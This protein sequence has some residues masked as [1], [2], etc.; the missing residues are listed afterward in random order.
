MDLYTRIGV[1]CVQ[2]L[3]AFDLIIRLLSTSYLSSLGFVERQVCLQPPPGANGL[4]I[5]K[6]INDMLWILLTFLIVVSS[7]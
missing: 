2:T 6:R 1:S 7:I 3:S 5:P 4:L